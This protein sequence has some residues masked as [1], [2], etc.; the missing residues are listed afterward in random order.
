MGSY[1]FRGEQ[2]A[3]KHKEARKTKIQREGKIKTRDLSGR[4]EEVV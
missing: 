4:V 3:D 2:E 1:S